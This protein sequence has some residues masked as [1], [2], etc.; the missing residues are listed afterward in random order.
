MTTPLRFQYVEETFRNYETTKANHP[1]LSQATLNEITGVVKTVDTKH[2]YVDLDPA[3][4][5]LKQIIP[6]VPNPDAEEVPSEIPVFAHDSMLARMGSV[7][8]LCSLIENRL[9][10]MYRQRMAVING[11]R[12]LTAAEEAEI[13]ENLPNNPDNVRI[14]KRDVTDAARIAR[15]LLWSHDIDS[16]TNA[17]LVQFTQVRNALV[18]DAMFRSARFN[19]DVLR[20]LQRLYTHMQNMRNKMVKRLKIERTFYANDPQRDARIAAQLEGIA[21]GTHMSRHSLYQRLAGSTRLDVPVV[22]QRFCYVVLPSNATGYPY[23]L[24]LE[25]PIR[26]LDQWNV[27]VA[28]A[29]LAVPVFQKIHQQNGEEKAVVFCGYGC[30]EQVIM[31]KSSTKPLTKS[32]VVRIDV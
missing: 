31:D 29:N 25:S 18:H 26:L 6:P 13:Y 27:T 5:H 28:M 4:Q 30:V 23:T 32:I 15:F 10:A 19:D 12:T 21:V 14:L 2:V 17:L 11:T 7:M 3:M 22:N 9:R 8:L 24:T 16:H 1:K 20:F